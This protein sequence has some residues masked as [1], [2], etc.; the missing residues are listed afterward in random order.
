MVKEVVCAGIPRSDDQRTRS[1]MR[2][3]RIMRRMENKKELKALLRRSMRK[4]YLEGILRALLVGGAAALA[5]LFAL[6]LGFHIATKPL[7]VGLA[8][9]VFAGAFAVC[10]IA[11]FF[12]FFRPDAKRAAS[13]VDQ[14]GLCDRVGT[15]LEFIDDGGDAASAQRRDTLS[16][17]KEGVRQPRFRFRAREF[18]LCAICALLAVTMLLLPHDLFSLRSNSETEREQQRQEEIAR[19]LI[20]K[21]KDKIKENEKNNGDALKEQLDKAV[22]DLEKDLDRAGSAEEKAAK[23]GNAQKKINRAF[24]ERDTR[25]GLGTALQRN[26]LTKKLGEAIEKGDREKAAKA[27]DELKEK[28]EG[29]DEKTDE[30]VKALRDAIEDAGKENDDLTDALR[31]LKED[32]ENARDEE[33]KEEAFSEAKEAV[34]R[35]LE[36]AN[37][38]D[39]EQKEMN[40]LLSEAKKEML[41]PGEEGEGQ[42]GQ[43]GEGQPQPGEGEGEGQ[44]QPGEGEGEMP[45]EGEGDQPGEG[46]EEGD[47]DGGNEGGDGP[48]SEDSGKFENEKNEWIYDIF[49][50]K[51]AYGEVYDAYYAE[52]LD[53]LRSGAITEEEKE[54]I[55]RYYERLG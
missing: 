1:G 4:L 22:R 7:S 53:A 28:T 47:G 34:D 37:A 33:K 52:Y 36:K 54:M 31:D 15:T 32:L 19:E 40:E 41:N 49:S 43:Q 14:E 18:L 24:E 13:R 6:S 21:L 30:L 11:A 42:E 51:V 8:L 20:E 44:P 35:A 27:L 23:I 50:G 38:R 12:L 39:K 3:E 9:T 55:D 25:K 16:R 46:E 5:A 45:G 48:G 26:E 2:Y 10:S 29:D 17:L